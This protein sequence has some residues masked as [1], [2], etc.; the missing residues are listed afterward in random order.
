MTKTRFVGYVTKYALTS[1][2]QKMELETCGASDFMVSSIPGAGML[3][4]HY[5][6][7]DWH[8]TFDEAKKRAEVMRDAKI[9]SNRKAIAKLEAMTFEEPAP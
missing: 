1:G 7:N 5:H 6:G 4:A 2:I 3:A 9:K 8:R